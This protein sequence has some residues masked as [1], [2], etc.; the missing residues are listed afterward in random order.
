[1]ML[2]NITFT[3]LLSYGI[4]LILF[5]LLSKI[6][7][8]L[9]IINF[10]KHNKG[11][12]FVN[13][14]LIVL[15]IAVVGG[16]A[17]FIGKNNSTYPPPTQQDYKSTTTDNI[18]ATNNQSNLKN[19]TVTSFLTGKTVTFSFSANLTAKKM[20]TEE[21]SSL[22]ALL[23]NSN[24]LAMSIYEIPSSI[25]LKEREKYSN[26]SSLGL[27]YIGE[28]KYNGYTVK[29]FLSV[30]IPPNPNAKQ[31]IWFADFDSY[32]LTISD[33]SEGKYSIDWSSFM[34]K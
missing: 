30:G 22:V 2:L 24:F 23:D 8:N 29:E 7:I 15:G 13:I 21:D 16:I 19:T 32:G 31:K 27:R 11:F 4:M 34:I 6:I 17:Y 20:K 25:I 3:I 26:Y 5:S 14:I 18:Q 33:D 28:Q 1:M 12:T 9:V 10:M